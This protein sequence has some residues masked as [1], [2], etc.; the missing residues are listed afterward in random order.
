MEQLGQS[1]TLGKVSLGLGVVSA[2]FVFGIGICALTGIQ[3]GWIGPLAT[4]LFICGASSAFLG[5][6]GVL[7]GIGGLFS[8][9]RSKVVAVIGII[10]SLMGMCLFV[11]FLGQAG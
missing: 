10:I 9:G 3:G 2:A 4:V 6:L 8:P 7:T 1:N 5:L 11:A